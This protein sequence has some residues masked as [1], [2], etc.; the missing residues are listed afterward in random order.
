MSERSD[1][2]QKT[3][4]RLLTQN[5]ELKRQANEALTILRLPWWHG[6]MFWRNHANDDLLKEGNKRLGGTKDRPTTERPEIADRQ[7]GGRG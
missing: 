6:L 2:Q 7:K 1:K 3:I 4:D 5:I